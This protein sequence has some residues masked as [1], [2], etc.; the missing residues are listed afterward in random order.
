MRTE[1]ELMLAL[2]QIAKGFRYIDSREVR[3]GSEHAYKFPMGK[4][5]YDIQSRLD[6]LVAAVG[7]PVELIDRGGAVIVRVVEKDYPLQLPFSPEHLKADRLLIGYDR[8]FA[9]IY[10]RLMHQLIGGASGAGKTMLIRFLLYQLIR[11]GAI[12]KI[13]D[14][15]GFSFFPFEVFPN[16]KVA[17][18][19]PE[20]AD[21]LHD[22]AS[23][24]ED[25]ENRIIRM[26][27]RGL[28]KTFKP[29]VII[30]DEA[31][32]IAP[33][34]HTG[35]MKEYARFCDETCARI[36][37]KGR[38]SKVIQFYCTQKPSAEIVNGQVKANVE[39]A[40]AF[41]TNNHYESK[42]ILDDT[43]AEK[44]SILTPGRCIYKA[45]RF[46]N[47]QVPFI[48]EEDEDW[49]KLLLPL[50]VEVIDNGSSH[51]SE[52]QRE[53]I[54]GSFSSTHSDN[55]TT[56][57]AQR[58]IGPEKESIKHTKGAGKRQIGAGE[59]SPP[60]ES[61]VSHSKGKAVA[62]S[63]TDEIAD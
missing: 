3:C 57:N 56:V 49:D 43:G 52:P 33:K 15:K 55:Q 35:K 58:F 14:L 59:I 28:T 50:K 45:E 16:V 17:K 25:R 8:L 20:A 62:A 63:Y 34:T 29:Y 6:T 48:G 9:P 38:E 61:L 31:A 36:S 44:I 7:G 39:S 24:L 30:I 11:M 32:Q 46:Y 41:R 26:R 1:K 4:C 19:L 51:R 13:V 12:I 54:E 42:V 5:M 18:N 27:D 40:I 23:E 10:I 53:Y 22:A 37:Q 2:N 47:L 21:L 60:R